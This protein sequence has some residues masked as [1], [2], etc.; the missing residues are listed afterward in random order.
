VADTILIEDLQLQACIG[1]FE[2]ERGVLQ[3]LAMDLRIRADLRPA[4]KSAKLDD[5]ICYHTVA[6]KIRELIASKEWVLVEQAAR[7]IC[8]ML[9]RFSPKVEAVRI[10]V[11]KFVVPGTRFAGVEI[12]RSRGDD[13]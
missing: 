13:F 12:E 6:A 8:A 11:R 2:E 5:T 9:F 10:Q 1:A 7:E 3:P 4:G